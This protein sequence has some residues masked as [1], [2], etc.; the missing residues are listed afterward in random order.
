MSDASRTSKA[1]IP[2]L[3]ILASSAPEK[4]PVCGMQVD[5]AKPAGKVEHKGKTYYFCSARCAERF[6]Q[7][8][9]KFL[10]APGAAEM[11]HGSAPTEQG[12]ILHTSSVAPSKSNEKKIRYTCPMHPEI[13]QIR[14]GSCPKCGMALEPMDIVAEEQ[15]DPEYES[16][17]K[18]FWVSLALSLPVLAISMFGGAAGLHLKPEAKNAVQLLLASPVVLWCGWPFFQ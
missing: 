2:G 10:A 17:H 9:E 11:H 8:A 4:D 5:P 1:S 6:S 3:P 7:D 15:A 16:M 14:P 18:R 12:A 13:V